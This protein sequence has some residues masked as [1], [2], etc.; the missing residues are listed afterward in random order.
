MSTVSEKKKYFLKNFIKNNFFKHLKLYLASGSLMAFERMI[1]CIR[2]CLI[3]KNVF[4][5][6]WIASKIVSRKNVINV[7]L[8]QY[9]DFTLL[10]STVLESLWPLWSCGLISEPITVSGNRITFGA[11]RSTPARGDGVCYKCEG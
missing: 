5:R 6:C 9:D 8:L 1:V 10:T 7:T 11:L 4:N 2:I 3:L